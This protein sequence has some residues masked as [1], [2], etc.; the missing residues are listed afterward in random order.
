MCCLSVSVCVCVGGVRTCRR[1]HGVF[2]LQG[3]ALQKA[4]Q[5]SLLL[6]GGIDGSRASRRFRRLVLVRRRLPVPNGGCLVVRSVLLAR[7]R[8]MS[9]VMAAR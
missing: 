7:V 8:V 4:L 9:R 6:L 2:H 3:D 1:H 5:G